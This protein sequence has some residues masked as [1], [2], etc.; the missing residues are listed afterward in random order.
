MDVSILILTYNEEKALPSCLDA[1]RWCED[2][3]VLDSGSRDQTI[4]IAQSCG[5]RVLVR[6]FDTFADQRNFGLENGAFK[7]EWVLHLDADEIVTEEFAACL[8]R[9]S[10]PDHLDGY[11][12]PAKQIL[13]GK[14][15]RFAGMYPTYQV[16][17]G[18]SNR[19]RFVQVGHGQREASSPDHLAYFPEPYLHYG[20]ERGMQHWL[21]KHIRYASDEATLI[22]NSPNLPPALD[23]KA[24]G[25]VKWR[26]LAKRVSLLL[27][28]W[29]RPFARFFYIYFLRFGFL[30]GRAGLVYALMLSVYEGMIA[31][32]VY[33]S[34]FRN[35]KRSGP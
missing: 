5:A 9:L 27:P 24:K 29:T 15:I 7:H 21:K 23:G 19:Q 12:V 8:K 33:E 10:P 30:D 25:R 1:L 32:F 17:L 35:E 16:R 11:F 6:P 14:W 18:R 13:F 20:F 4:Q 2:I 31:I 28:P 34:L 26:R 22:V 3:V